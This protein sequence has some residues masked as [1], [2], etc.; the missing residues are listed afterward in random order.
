MISTSRYVEI[1]LDNMKTYSVEYTKIILEASSEVDVLLK[2]IYMALGSKKQRPNLGDYCSVTKTKLETLISEGLCLEQY[3]ISLNPFEEW[4]TNEE[5]CWHKAYNNIKHNRGVHYKDAN[6]ENALLSLGAL[7][8][9]VV[10]Y[11]LCTTPLKT[12]IEDRHLLDFIQSLGPK[13]K[14]ISFSKYLN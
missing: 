12:G 13:Q 4:K 5:P 2:Q 3:G 8:S 9:T 7:Y 11:Y 14:L 1:A 10:H 6:L